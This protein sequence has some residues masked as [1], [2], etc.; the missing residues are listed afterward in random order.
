[1]LQLSNKLICNENSNVYSSAS[2]SG[3]FAEENPPWKIGSQKILVISI[4]I[5]NYLFSVWKKQYKIYNWYF[6]SFPNV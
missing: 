4:H 6:S 2:F 5:R 1:M 3:N